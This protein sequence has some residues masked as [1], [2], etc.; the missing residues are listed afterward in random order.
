MTFKPITDFR[1]TARDPAVEVVCEFCLYSEHHLCPRELIIPEPS[2]RA[3][4]YKCA[5]HACRCAK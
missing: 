4:T 1:W 3:G 5:C 2:R